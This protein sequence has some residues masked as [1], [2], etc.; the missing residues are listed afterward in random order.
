VVGG[1]G[2]LRVYLGRNWRLTVEGFRRVLGNVQQF[3]DD[4][5]DDDVF[6]KCEKEKMSLQKRVFC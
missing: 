3:D 4:D 1:E 6:Y 5:D 2:L